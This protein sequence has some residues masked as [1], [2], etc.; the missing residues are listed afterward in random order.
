MAEAEINSSKRSFHG[1]WLRLDLFLYIYI[2]PLLL[3]MKRNKNNILLVQIIYT[4]RIDKNKKSHI[5]V[6]KEI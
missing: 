2:N 1:E 5:P 6:E 3:T 4:P